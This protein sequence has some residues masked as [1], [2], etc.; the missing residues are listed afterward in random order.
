MHGARV[1]TSIGH[2]RQTTLSIMIESQC[3]GTHSAAASVST[4]ERMSAPFITYSWPAIASHVP[5]AFQHRILPLRPVVTCWSLVGHRISGDL[6][7]TR[8]PTGEV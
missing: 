8:S 7:A 6:A 2:S 5:R 1:S 4:E 3:Q